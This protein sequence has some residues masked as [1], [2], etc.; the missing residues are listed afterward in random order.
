MR[1]S[2]RGARTIVVLLAATLALMTF[3]AP[4]GAATPQQVNIVAE[5]VLGRDLRGHRECR[6]ERSDLRAWNDAGYRLRL[7]R[8]AERAFRPG[9]HPQ[10]IHLYRVLGAGRSSSRSR[11]TPCSAGR[12]HSAGSCRAERA[13]TKISGAAATVSPWTQSRMATPTSM[14]DSSSIELFATR[15]R[16]GRRLATPANRSRVLGKPAEHRIVQRSV[17]LR[18]GHRVE[19]SVKSARNGQEQVSRRCLER[20]P[21]RMRKALR[22]AAHPARLEDCGSIAKA[23]LERTL[24]DVSDLVFAAVHVEPVA[25][26]RLEHRFEDVDR[27]PGLLARQPVRD[28]EEV[29]HL[30][31][32]RRREDRLRIIRLHDRQPGARRKS[33]IESSIDQHLDTCRATPHR[34]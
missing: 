19:P 4:V 24:Q 10:G 17:A 32:V 28:R 27:A 13:P 7:R 3:I 23:D 33:G 21:D 16:P 8:L 12:S 1:N 30:A 14:T 5:H 34:V 11:S 26:T 9:P 31:C 20:I 15:A 18:S 2:N 29:E 25:G 22:Q 6:R